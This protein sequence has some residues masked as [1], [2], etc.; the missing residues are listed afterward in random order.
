MIVLG[1]FAYVFGNTN[2]NHS[3]NNTLPLFANTSKHDIIAA[4]RLAD[5]SLGAIA[6]YARSCACGIGA[7]RKNALASKHFYLWHNAFS[8]L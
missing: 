4:K 7:R 3:V 1:I 2:C 6:L 8:K 5:A